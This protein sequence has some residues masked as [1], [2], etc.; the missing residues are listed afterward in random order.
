METVLLQP[1]TVKSLGKT[2]LI[3]GSTLTLFA[4]AGASTVTY[5][6]YFV[7]YYTAASGLSLIAAGLVSLISSINWEN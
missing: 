2:A 1:L 3:A 4:I 6:S 5:P 7:Y